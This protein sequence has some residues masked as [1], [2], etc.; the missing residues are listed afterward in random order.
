[1]ISPVDSEAS[2]RRCPPD[3]V[4]PGVGALELAGDL[5]RDNIERRSPPVDL[6]EVDESDV[7]AGPHLGGL[8]PA[9]VGRT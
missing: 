9:R 6:V 1:M 8:S 5:L 4:R 7:I 2:A 3:A